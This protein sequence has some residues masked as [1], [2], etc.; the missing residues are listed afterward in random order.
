M[1]KIFYS[2][3]LEVNSYMDDII[4][5]TLEECREWC[6]DHHYT[7]ADGGIA[8]I[9]DDGDPLVTAYFDIEGIED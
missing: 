6:K 7:N 4:N 8:E 3:E 9:T 2:V 5:G 1:A